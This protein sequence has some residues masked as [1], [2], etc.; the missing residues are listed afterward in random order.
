MIA[1]PGEGESACQL[2]TKPGRPG[3]L[4]NAPKRSAWGLQPP[5]VDVQ[6][7]GDMQE[8]PW[9]PNERWVP[10]LTG[11]SGAQRLSWTNTWGD[12][13]QLRLYSYEQGLSQPQLVWETETERGTYSPYTLV[14]G[15]DGDGRPEIAVARMGGMSIF[16]G[17]TG[18][19]KAAFDYRPGHHR[20]YGFFGA[21][22]DVSG[23]TLFVTVGDFSGHV[24][25]VSYR[26]G[27]LRLLWMTLFDPQ[28]EQGIDRRYTINR[29]VPDPVAVVNGAGDR[30]IL[31]SVF[32]S[33]GDQRWHTL[34]YDLPTGRIVFDL[35]D[36]YL[37]GLA[38][39]N[40]DGRQELFC[41]VLPT[42]AEPTYAPLELIGF[43]ASGK[44]GVLWRVGEGRWNFHT[45][46]AQPLNRW[47]GQTLGTQMLVTRRTQ[48]GTEFYVS[49]PQA[50][51]LGERLEAW[52]APTGGGAIRKTW[53]A[54]TTGRAEVEVSVVGPDAQELLI[55][56]R[57][58][59]R[60][61]LRLRGARGEV[62]CARARAGAAP[63]IAPAKDAKGAPW[64]IAADVS[65]RVSLLRF[66]RDR[67]RPMA[68]FPGRPM[69]TNGEWAP[70]GLIAVD[71]DGDGAD[72]VLFAQEGPGGGARLVVMGLDGR[73]RWH[74][75]FPDFSGRLRAWNMGG[76]TCWIA[77]HFRDRR[78]LDVAVSLRRSIMHSDETFMLDGRTGAII[79]HR[80]VLEVK[81]PP[82][83]RGFGGELMAV[84]DIDGDGRDG[85][86]L[87]YPAELSVT[88]GATG[89][90]KA[91]YN[92]GP[93]PTADM[94][95]NMWV[96]GGV[97]QVADLDN[98]GHL[99]ILWAQNRTLLSA[100]K[101]TQSRLTM[102]WHSDKDQ[103]TSA[104][105]A[106]ARLKTGEHVIGAGGFPDGF[107][108]INGKDGSARWVY[109]L[110]DAPVSN[111]LAEDVDGNGEVEFVFASG[112]RL[113][114]L[115]AG[116]GEERWTFDC[117][118]AATQILFC[119]TGETTRL[120]AATV[121]GDLVCIGLG[122][123]GR[124]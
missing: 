37:S 10:S 61:S 100:F 115:D 86:I 25:V 94:P 89:V 41:Q 101:L 103:G 48:R 117:P 64:V 76:M 15:F 28:S 113:H 32:N 18:K 98:D 39:V 11:G 68:Q 16:D 24:D 118:D 22:P 114:A 90:V 106:I 116:T 40:G 23:G 107:R 21:Y 80:D 93:I 4:W 34:G 33:T 52:M 84:A 83:T 8:V 108:A 71:L 102:M 110:T 121:T 3:I 7:D 74:H 59:G 91:V 55:L 6:G 35:P 29:V 111:T 36:R 53:D 122:S 26:D 1:T 50:R 88:D 75:D 47:W 63:C 19:R 20:H 62:V 44:A 81:D 43:D 78:R 13:G 96:I 97:P 5:L 72:E 70:R 104:Q 123:D 46:I 85:L 38:D 120:L 56:T 82:H 99:E 31:L 124:R 17:T 58:R 45:A 12:E 95:G 27:V 57:S 51:R 79:W 66:E 77:G 54:E 73:E 67:L 69:T 49:L 105:P 92:M 60:A 109:A 87:C 14:G 2:G 42:R 112:T 30:A 9:G 119:R 65:R